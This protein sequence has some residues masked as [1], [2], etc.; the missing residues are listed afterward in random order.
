MYFHPIV[1]PALGALLVFN[2][3]LPSGT[4]AMPASSARV[5]GHDPWD[6][7]GQ[8]EWLPDGRAVFR[9]T[10]G[11]VVYVGPWWPFNLG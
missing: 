5:S 3:I 2:M 4:Q 1:W 8:P 10:A 11:D 6:F 9:N 7:D